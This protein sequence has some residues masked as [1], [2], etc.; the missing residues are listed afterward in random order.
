MTCDRCQ[1]SK[2]YSGDWYLGLCPECADETEGTWICRRCSRN[3]T[4]ETMGGDCESDPA[5]CGIP[6]DQMIMSI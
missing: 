2:P 4:F 6:C 3:G 5:C 1:E